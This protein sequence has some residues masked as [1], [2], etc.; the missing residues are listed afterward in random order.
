M[1]KIG[2]MVGF[3]A[4]ANFPKRS[5]RYVLSWRYVAISAL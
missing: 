5:R 4:R 1:L 3:G 2:G